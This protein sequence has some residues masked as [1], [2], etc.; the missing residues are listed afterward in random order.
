MARPGVLR[1]VLGLGL[2]PSGPG[3]GTRVQPQIRRLKSS[4]PVPGDSGLRGRP[5]GLPSRTSA[6]PARDFSADAPQDA[7]ILSVQDLAAAQEAVRLDRLDREGE[8]RTGG[9][10]DSPAGTG[11]AGR[12]TPGQ[13]APPAAAPPASPPS[14]L[15]LLLLLLLFLRR[16]L[17]RRQKAP[18]PSARTPPRPA[19]LSTRPPAKPAAA[20][21]R[22]AHRG[23]PRPRRPG[24]R[25]CSRPC[26]C[27]CSVTGP[28]GPAGGYLPC[29]SWPPCCLARARS[30]SR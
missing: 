9:A 25:Y 1:C 4:G 11:S 16:L 8:R 20:P 15:L 10:G 30:P 22:P 28:P 13:G 17:L 12:G 24:A 7:V 26:G 19:R 2:T 6:R 27:G 3:G 21:V 14:P 23:G 5:D 29:W 18:R